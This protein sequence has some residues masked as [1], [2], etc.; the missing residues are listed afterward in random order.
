M[1]DVEKILDPPYVSNTKHSFTEKI[2]TGFQELEVDL[3]PISVIIPQHYQTEDCAQELINTLQFLETDLIRQRNRVLNGGQIQTS[4]KNINLNQDIQKNEEELYVFD[5]RWGLREIRPNEANLLYLQISKPK[6]FIAE[7]VAK[8][9]LA[10]KQVLDSSS[11]LSDHQIGCNIIGLFVADMLGVENIR[12]RCYFKKHNRDFKVHRAMSIEIK[13][14]VCLLLISV[15]GFF[16]SICLSYGANKNSIWK[17]IWITIVSLKCIFDLSVKEMLMSVIV[18][19]GIPNIIKDEVSEIRQELILS[20]LKL[21]KP[22]PVFHFNRFSASDFLFSSMKVAKMYPHLIESKLIF[23]YRNANPSPV[24][25]VLRSKRI[26]ASFDSTHG[27]YSWEVL[28][29]TALTILLHFGSLHKA[30]QKV[31]VSTIPTSLFVVVGVS[32]IV[33]GPLAVHFMYSSDVDVKD[34]LETILS[35]FNQEDS[36]ESMLSLSDDDKSDNEKHDNSSWLN[37]LTPATNE[38]I[39]EKV[40]KNEVEHEET[41]E[42]VGTLSP[43]TSINSPSTNTLSPI[44]E[45]E[46]DLDEADDFHEDQLSSSSKIPVEDNDTEGDLSMTGMVSSTGKKMK[47]RRSQL[48]RASLMKKRIAN[49]HQLAIESEE[50]TKRNNK[51]RLNKRLDQK[52]SQVNN[53]N[54]DDNNNAIPVVKLPSASIEKED[55]FTSVANSI[56]NDADT[57]AIIT[58]NADG[59]QVRQVL[60]V[61]KNAPRNTFVP[62]RRRST[63]TKNKTLKKHSS[64]TIREMKKRVNEAVVDHENELLKEKANRFERMNDRIKAR[65]KLEE[66]EEGR[67]DAFDMSNTGMQ[68]ILKKDYDDFM[69]SG[70]EDDLVAS[71]SDDDDSS[72]IRPTEVVNILRTSEPTRLRK[73]KNTSN[74][75]GRRR[76]TIR[77]AAKNKAI[78]TIK[79]SSN[80]GRGRKSMKVGRKQSIVAKLLETQLHVDQRKDIAEE[81][82]DD[83]IGLQDIVEDSYGS[84]SDDSSLNY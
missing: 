39:D 12:S 2:M 57:D 55:E 29:L 37:I 61:T 25:D 27:R 46:E 69:A 3:S 36:D 38:S 19:Y 75:K 71:G 82:S 35:Q 32:I 79:S 16:I 9:Y 78:T 67:L 6:T 68:Q 80:T 45:N 24:Q 33:C 70:S 58:V 74:T 30:I 7:K 47:R 62:A 63:L 54:D 66:S 34:D 28:F 5:L 15:Y 18:G 52:R 72:Q 26:Q 22:R 4:R 21:L 64:N 77:K 60:S 73:F 51:N 56:L 8:S 31:I 1:G 13:L 14:L 23:M 53:N 83:S 41:D 84:E 20:G 65:K 42:S 10:A 49:A 76:S 43:I 48:R 40:V 44:F 50:A 81:S 59:T 17:N 11:T